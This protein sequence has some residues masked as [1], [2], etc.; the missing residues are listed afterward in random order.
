MS[1]C[2]RWFLALGPTVPTAIKTLLGAVLFAGAPAAWALS[3][4][5]CEPEWGALVKTIYPR[6]EVFSATSALQDPH[7]IE[8]RPSL[9]ARLRSADIAVCTGAGLESSWL[10]IL[11][12]RAGNPQV[13]DGETGMVYLAQAVT[14][15]DPIRGVVTPFSGDLHAD[16]NPHF[17]LDPQRLLQ[18]GR[19][20]RDRIAKV[21]PD[22]SAQIL[23]NFERFELEFSERI[24]RWERL[25]EPLRGKKVMTQHVSFGYL[26]AWLMIAPI[27]DLEPKPG[28]APTPG[29]L[30]RLR[31]EMAVTPVAAI[32]IARHH[33]RRP[34]EWLSRQAEGK[35]VPLVVL[36]ATVSVMSSSG[37]IEWFDGLI[38]TLLQQARQ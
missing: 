11:Q 20:L 36:P 5:V 14:L 13:Q 31:R 30:E 23:A 7:Y 1:S 32:V 26:W 4:F 25:A 34:A 37:I 29:H 24:K 28:M 15:I 19:V 2:F 12:A 17:H 27:A 16:G 38:A 33:D 21:R 35:G 8:A 10:P 18:A 22:E 9:I 3:V 6:A